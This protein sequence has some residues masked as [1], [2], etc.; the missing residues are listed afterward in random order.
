MSTSSTR[1]RAFL[2]VALLT[3]AASFTVGRRLP[4]LSRWIV[5]PD[6]L[7]VEPTPADGKPLLAPNTGK[8]LLFVYVGSSVCGPSGSA[9]LPRMVRALQG[10]IKANAKEHGFD[11]V[12]IG[13]AAEQDPIAGLRHLM[14]VARFD[15]IA[16][17][18]SQLNQALAHFVHVDHRGLAATP[19][20]I[21]LERLL[22]EDAFGTVDPSTI[23]E[24]VL[25]RKVGLAELQNWLSLRAPLPLRL[26]AETVAN[27]Y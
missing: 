13:I 15:E 24:R 27:R 18:Q 3:L 6:V 17:G 21:I 23:K 16:A 4:T 2:A 12:A 1:S 11:L 5:Q 19:Q 7:T 26:S 22:V 10:L 9:D 25:L 8:Q 20:V 14:S